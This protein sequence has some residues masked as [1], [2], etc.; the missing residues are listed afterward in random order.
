MSAPALRTLARR[1]LREAEVRG[2]RVLL[3]LSGGGDS[4]ALLHVLAGL[5]KAEGFTLFAHGVDH[6]LRAGAAAELDLAAALADRLDVPFARSRVEL[7]QGGNVHARA[8]KARYDALE[9]ARAAADATFVATAHHRRD[10]AETVLL[11]LLRG[12]PAA[13]LGVLP[14]VEGRRLRPFVHAPFELIQTYL[15]HHR[16][17]FADDPSNRDPR[18]LR[19]RVR[20]ELLPL[21]RELGPNIEST[22]C[23]LADALSDD[24]PREH[25]A[26]LAVLHALPRG[27]L[28]A[29]RRMAEGSSPHA[30]IL[31]PG[32][33]A[34]SWDAPHSK[35]QV[36]AEFSTSQGSSR[37][38]AK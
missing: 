24:S 9:R 13:G 10:R 21:L 38:L 1:V 12:A 32:G 20:H 2:R 16:L 18:Y 6:G 8:R 26:D 15:A 35:I 37:R 14:A 28:Q 36:E 4:M 7:E 22:L 23:A 17:R 33:L 11:R 34:A 29:L 31:L 5:S 3:A 19:T 25:A 27:T 30:R